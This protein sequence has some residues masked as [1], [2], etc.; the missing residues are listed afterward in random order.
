MR[1]GIPRAL[2]YYEFYPLWS[3]FIERLGHEV[4]LSGRTT[5]AILE[6]GVALAV[7]EA[8][9]P[10]KL[11]L[12]H[13]ADLVGRCDAIFLP[14][15]ITIEKNGFLCPKLVGLP[16]M[17]RA[18]PI[19]CPRLIASTVDVDADPELVNPFIVAARELGMSSSEGRAA[20][21]EAAR[22]QSRFMASVRAGRTLARALDDFEKGS[23][24]APE[25][26]ARADLKREGRGDGRGKLRIALLGHP[27]NIHDPYLS[28]DVT[29]KLASL[30]C[31]VVPTEMVPP[32]DCEA[33]LEEFG[34][35]V[36]WVFGRRVIGPVLHLM[37]T[38]AVDGIVYL[39]SFGCGPDAL[40]KGIADL[41]AK[42]RPDVPYMSV[43]LDEH[44]AD[45]GLVT[46]LEAFVDMVRR[47]KTLGKCTTP[48]REEPGPRKSEAKKPDTAAPRPPEARSHAISFPHMG[49]LHIPLR[50]MIEALGLNCLVPPASTRRTLDIGSAHSPELACLPFKLS[51]G[52][53][54]EALEAG[55]T[56]I[57]GLSSRFGA[58]CRLYFFPAAQGEILRDMGYD[59]EMIALDS[60]RRDSGGEIAKATKARAGISKWRFAKA[61]VWVFVRKLLACEQAERLAHEARAHAVRPEEVSPILARTLDAIDR[62][63]PRRLRGIM[64]SARDAF[65]AIERDPDRRPLRIGIVGELFVLLDQ[66]SNHNIEEK[67][68]EM[69]V[70]VKR[71][72]WA[73]KKIL[74]T[75]C[76]RLDPEYSG[77]MEA[78]TRYLGVDIGAECNA[79][80]GD[81]IEYKRHGYD[82]LVHL[83]PFSCMPEIVAESVLPVARRDSEMPV[84]TFALD[85]QTSTA[86]MMTRLE[87][88]V[89]L[90]GRQRK[91]RVHA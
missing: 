81:V 23:L 19:S 9:L 52:N 60:G 4:V 20:Y 53:Y 70:F 24:L 15:L 58:S 56:H 68:G 54:V 88:F 44:S 59:F 35:N 16:D 46:R 57:L 75:L 61:F 27:Y 13:V 31:E 79:T 78:A 50:G 86:G 38:G 49:T 14:R 2:M 41:L 12:G 74:R 32:E 63:E 7:D 89:D 72:F 91:G 3:T 51:L 65:G 64:R 77:A 18:L 37:E 21:E 71:N 10:V 29:D 48:S 90:L 28:M 47:A 45:A 36:Y 39:V 67:L 11:A 6:K 1:V 40:L 85:E 34:H 69:G 42:K 30:G 84:I 73:S 80:V 76:R 8:C 55:A 17:V 5:R 83:M 43:V 82:G 33:S 22:A 66:F 26:V 87:A 62:C 25:D